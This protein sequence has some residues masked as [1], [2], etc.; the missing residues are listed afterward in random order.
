M[1]DQLAAD[2]IPDP[3]AAEGKQHFRQTA[4]QQK[5]ES[6]AGECRREPQLRRTVQPVDVL[7]VIEFRM[8]FSARL[9]NPLRGKIRD[10]LLET[11]QLR[12]VDAGVREAERL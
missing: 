12:G 1:L 11:V 3:C 6:T 4:T 8:Q 7:D 2:R 5:R 9:V 10:E